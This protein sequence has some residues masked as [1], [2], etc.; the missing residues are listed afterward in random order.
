[1]TT[2]LPNAGPPIKVSGPT[3]EQRHKN[4][5]R[6]GKWRARWRVLLTGATEPKMCSEGGF[7]TKTHAEQWAT[8]IHRA[9]AG[10]DG[11]YFDADGQPVQARTQSASTATCLEDFEVFVHRVGRIEWASDDHYEKQRS[12]LVRGLAHMLDDS[13]L[14]APLLDAWERQN[15][16]QKSRPE[17]TTDVEWAGR[18][19][20]D[21]YLARGDVAPTSPAEATGLDRGRQWLQAHS[22]TQDQVTPDAL[23]PLHGYL[24]FNA[25]GSPRPAATSRSYW[26][27]IRRVMTWLTDEGFYANNPAS[28]FSHRRRDP[29]AQKVDPHRIPDQPTLWRIAISVAMRAGRITEGVLVLVM[30]YAALRIGEACDLRRRDVEDEDE[31]GMWL[32]VATQWDAPGNGN[33]ENPAPSR[34]TK[35]HGSEAAARRLIYVPRRLARILRW[36][37][38]NHV[39]QAASAPLFP[40]KRSARGRA[41]HVPGARLEAR[42]RRDVQG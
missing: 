33:R 21:G 26:G 13:S 2:G 20:R 39:D 40:G 9:H 7:A 16:G 35:G 8:R 27:L 28:G 30:A 17:P 42:D 32:S 34:P 15:R 23:A 37:M 1:M 5:K 4:G 12:L 10:V 14:T 18:Y 36:Y 38:T 24:H 41:G 22:L 6:S 3:F 11:W 25:D 19:L 31:G 29:D